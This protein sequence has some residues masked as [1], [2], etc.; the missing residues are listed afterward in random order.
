M[1]WIYLSVSAN[2]PKKEWL[3]FEGD[4]MS[5]TPQLQ[6]KDTSDPQ[7]AVGKVFLPYVENLIELAESWKN[8]Y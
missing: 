6:N 3:Y 5:Y 7:P 4:K 2:G 1:S 8:T